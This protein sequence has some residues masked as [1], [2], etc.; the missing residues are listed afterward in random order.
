MIQR[1]YKTHIKN[2]QGIYWQTEKSHSVQVNQNF[3]KRYSWTH[4]TATFSQYDPSIQYTCKNKQLDYTKCISNDSSAVHI[5][6]HEDK[7]PIISKKTEKWDWNRTRKTEK[8]QK[9]TKTHKRLGNSFT[10]F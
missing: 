1:S 10:I 4:R 5:L 9:Y 6:V 8:E 3:P 7:S 2:H